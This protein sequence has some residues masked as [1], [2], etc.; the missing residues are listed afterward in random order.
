MDVLPSDVIGLIFEYICVK[1]DILS[2]RS[3]SQKWKH[4]TERFVETITPTRNIYIPSTITGLCNIEHVNELRRMYYAR[5]IG[6]FRRFS[7]KIFQLLPQL[8]FIAPIGDDKHAIPLVVDSIQEIPLLTEQTTSE[9]LDVYLVKCVPDML[10]HYNNDDDDDQGTFTNI[11]QQIHT[12][13]KELFVACFQFISKYRKQRNLSFS[14]TCNIPYLGY[15]PDYE[16]ITFH[17]L[18]GVIIISG[19]DAYCGGTSIMKDFRDGDFMMSQ[20][21]SIA[22]YVTGLSTWFLRFDSVWENNFL[23]NL[24]NLTTIRVYRQTFD[25]KIFSILTE[26]S[27]IDTLIHT[28][29]ESLSKKFGDTRSIGNMIYMYTQLR[30]VISVPCLKSVNLILPFY[31]S[32]LRKMLEL[33]PNTRSVGLLNVEEPEIDYSEY[34]SDYIYRSFDLPLPIE[35]ILSVINSVRSRGIKHL[36]IYTKNKLDELPAYSDLSIEVYMMIDVY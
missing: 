21:I 22:P 24:P 6:N 3:V 32:S 36:R 17:Y 35:D 13:A 19:I 10:A 5:D 31:S 2:C 8:K 7:P 1:Q 15:R 30:M 34:H 12:V 18:R 29:R 4:Y 23:V 14:V 26:S 9:S 27:T 33:F 20:L 28:Y 16:R 11:C 25:T